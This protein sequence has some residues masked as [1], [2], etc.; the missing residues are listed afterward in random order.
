M[1]VRE[2]GKKWQL[3]GELNPQ[4]NPQAYS[5]TQHKL[6]LHVLRVKAFGYVAQLILKI[7]GGSFNSKYC[8]K[9]WDLVT[10][11]LPSTGFLRQYLPYSRQ[12]SEEPILTWYN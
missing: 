10:L 9:W 6:I 5:H 11:T 2:W 7:L 4:L 8:S 12:S 1:C 3:Q